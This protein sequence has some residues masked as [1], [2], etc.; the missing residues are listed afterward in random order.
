MEASGRTVRVRTDVVCPTACL[1]NSWDG[2]LKQLS[3]NHRSQVRHSYRQFGGQEQLRFRSVDQSGAD[4][5]SRELIRLNRSRMRRKG[6]VSSLEDDV[7]RSFLKEAISY[8]ASRGY[9]WMDT[10]ERD[11]EVLGSALNFVHG[12]SVYYYMGGFDNKIGKLRPGTALFALIIRRS[13]DAGYAKYN[14]LRGVES[15]KY[16][17]CAK[18]VLSHRV[19]IY[20]RG[21][22]RGFLVSAVDDLYFKLRNVLKFARS[23]VSRRG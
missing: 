3:S 12:D 6:K 8:M 16:R 5:F 14:F 18:D 23:L 1:P 20:P 10:I 2:Y 15:Y 21:V 19:V 9:A 4:S 22:T 11:N 17:W 13:I 7:F